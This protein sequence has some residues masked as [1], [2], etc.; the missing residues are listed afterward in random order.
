MSEQ[1]KA[2]ALALG[3]NSPDKWG[4][5]PPLATC[6]RCSAPLISTLLWHGKEFVCIECGLHLGFVEPQPAE[7][8]AE[9]RE[10]YEALLAEWAQA[11]EGKDLEEISAWL[12]ERVEAKGAGT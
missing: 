7:D 1:V 2:L 6:T 12:K 5:K 8:T 10:R 11:T 9:L 3:S 4:G